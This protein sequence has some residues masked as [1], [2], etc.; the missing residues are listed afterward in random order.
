MAWLLTGGAGYIGSHII[1]AFGD[2]DIDVVVLD[3]LSSGFREFVPDG[4]P[5]VVGSVI[6]TEIVAG[7][8]R[9]YDITG[10]VHLAG[11][12]YAGVSME[13]PTVFYRDNIYGM[14]VI[15]DAMREAG[16]TN[17][18][19]SSS[20]ATY[21]TPAEEVVTEATPTGPESPYGESKL[22]SEWLL[23]RVADTWPELR[24]TSLRYF[25]VVGSGPQ[26]LAD[27]SPYNLF[28]L[29]FRALDAGE[30][31]KIFGDDYPT[32]DGTCIRDYIHVVDLA[33]AHVVAAQALESGRHVA[34]IY[35]VG[36]GEG[37]TVREIMDAVREGTSV[38]FEPVVVPRRPGDPARIVASADRID[39]DLGWVASRDLDDMVTSAWAS[40]QHHTAAGGDARLSHQ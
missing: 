38:G 12:K 28:P 22:V 14:G 23:R 8:F 33:E 3:N 36:R 31:P 10:V 4:V 30:S 25:N 34:P 5:L 18:V 19:F 27:H 16:C 6:D 17:M 39:E 2:A 40:W 7:V 1:R 21:G 9:D 37:S 35:N 26:E 15:L 13:Q 24:Q 29:I 11:W 20:C 32:R